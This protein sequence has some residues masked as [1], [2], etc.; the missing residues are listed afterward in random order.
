MKKALIVTFLLL[1]LVAPAAAQD[2]KALT[3]AYKFDSD[4]TSFTFCRLEG[5]GGSPEGAPIKGLGT[6]TAAA[7]A[8]I[9]NS[10]TTGFSVGSAVVAKD[11]VV[12][13]DTP[14]TIVSVTDGDTIVIDTA[15]T[16]TAGNW[17]Y[18]KS[19]CGTAATSGWVDVEPY[20]DKTLVMEYLQGDIALDVVWQCKASYLGAGIVTVYP[21]ATTD[22][23]GGT[24]VAASTTVPPF[25]RF[26]AATSGIQPTTLAVVSYEPWSQ[27][28]IGLKS[29]ADASDASTNLEQITLGVLQ[30]LRR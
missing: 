24:F 30:R 11:V 8:T 5:V 4:A 13:N 20:A 14:Y 9:E 29:A 26:A 23:P 1:G 6:V 28:R 19:V 2:T 21:N 27:C 12:I 18:L 16:V 10:S 22:C 7:S 17:F 25:C 15:I 3:L